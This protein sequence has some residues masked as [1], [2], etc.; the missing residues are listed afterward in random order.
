MISAIVRCYSL[1]FM[2]DK[3]LRNL[4]DIDFVLLAVCN[5]TDSEKPCEVWELVKNLN[6]KNVYCVNFP[7]MSQKD[8]F[9]EC[10][11]R[12]SRMGSEIIL[13]NDA[14][15][16]LLRDDRDRIISEMISNQNDFDAVNVSVVDYSNMEAS[17]RYE[18]RTHKP[19]VAVKPNARFNGNR[20]VE[21][22]AL[23]EKTTLHHFGYA[24]DE[25]DMNWKMKNLWY[26][27]ESAQ[28]IINSP[29][30]KANP[31]LELMEVMA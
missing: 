21:Q 30:E 2:L 18:L 22:G 26:Q 20:S 6:Q 14:D 10:I 23:M 3:V 1:T 12:L 11:I 31:P 25:N 24:L 28:K 4:S 7:K 29:K 27:R 5:Y 13:I 16:I 8:L 15:E 9:N 17:E 19:V